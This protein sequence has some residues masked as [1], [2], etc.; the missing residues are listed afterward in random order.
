MAAPRAF[1]LKRLRNPSRQ[2]VRLIRVAGPPVH[3]EGHRRIF[4]LKPRERAGSE[5]VRPT[6]PPRRV[7]T[8]RKQMIP[9]CVKKGKTSHGQWTVLCLYKHV[10]GCVS[11][12]TL[13]RRH[14]RIAMFAPRLTKNVVHSSIPPHSCLS[15]FLPRKIQTP[16]GFAV[17]PV[18][19]LALQRR[20]VF[21]DIQVYIAFHTIQISYTHHDA[22]Q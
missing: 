11:V 4:F 15:Q 22:F 17:T 9:R 14:V 21:E 7:T 10:R 19:R 2:R 5:R 18:C 6:G 3:A 16:Q 8:F 1:V 20:I 13:Q 12:G